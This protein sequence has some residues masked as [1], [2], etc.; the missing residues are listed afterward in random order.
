MFKLIRLFVVQYLNS[1]RNNY[2]NTRQY[3]GFLPGSHQHDFIVH[4]E[5]GEKADDRNQADCQS[6]GAKGAQLPAPDLC[7]G[8]DEV[9]GANYPH[10]IPCEATIT[11][12]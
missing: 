4:H 5:N 11:E 2:P 10:Q 1:V 9:F 6:A 8:G 7:D 3:Q 12:L